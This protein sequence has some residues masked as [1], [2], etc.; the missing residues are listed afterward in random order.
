MLH[1]TRYVE[2]PVLRRGCLIANALEWNAH[3]HFVTVRRHTTL[4][5]PDEIRAEIRQRAAS[6]CVVG[7]AESGGVVGSATLHQ[8]S[9]GLTA[10]RIHLEDECLTTVVKG[11]QQEFDAIFRV[12]VIAIG[13]IR[14]HGLVRFI[15]AHAEVDGGRRVPH[16]DFR[17]IS[18]GHTI[19]WRELREAGESRRLL[20]LRLVQLA[21]HRD[22]AIQPR[23][24]NAKL[25]CATVIGDG[26]RRRSPGR[27]DW[28]WYDWSWCGSDGR[29]EQR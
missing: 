19:R 11:A 4:R 5:L 8:C 22:V 18:R 2:A 13:E 15:R 3:F 16:Q 17:R 7:S 10:E 14:M 28:N 1:V 23:R 29:D 20:P 6:G 24:R 27:R 12:Y 26:R 9:V 25:T 21:V